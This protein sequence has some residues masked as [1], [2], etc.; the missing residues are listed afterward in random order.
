MHFSAVSQS[1]P[2]SARTHHSCGLLLRSLTFFYILR[3]SII[4]PQ[5]K[6]VERGTAL[7]PRQ[8]LSTTSWGKAGAR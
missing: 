7:S 8:T 2:V 6:N 1:D 4:R 3:G 5:R